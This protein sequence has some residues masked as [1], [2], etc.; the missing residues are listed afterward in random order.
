[1]A[2]IERRQKIRLRTLHPK[3]I[4]VVEK[5]LDSDG[6]R[7]QLKAANQVLN[8]TDPVIGI[9]EHRVEHTVNVTEMRLL[10]ER[11]A[12]EMRLPVERLWGVNEGAPLPPMI[13]AEPVTIEAEV[14]PDDD[15]EDDGPAWDES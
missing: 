15:D 11:L 4:D 9:Q 1:V 7:D 8:R 10:V 13:E 12:Q 3:A 2:E 14:E 6:H 5:I